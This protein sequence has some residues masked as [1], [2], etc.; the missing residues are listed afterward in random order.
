MSASNGQGTKEHL[1]KLTIL[2]EQESPAEDIMPAMAACIIDMAKNYE[3]EKKR[4]KETEDRQKRYETILFGDEKLGVKGLVEDVK[5]IIATYRK[6]GW[7]AA[8]I[9]IP[10]G[11]LFYFLFDLLKEHLTK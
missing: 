9:W 2:V 7:L 8:L 4:Q 3:E 5:P 1:A 6:F 10:I 11:G